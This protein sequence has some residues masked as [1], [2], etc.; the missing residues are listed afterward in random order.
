M[1][2]MGLWVTG[3]GHNNT[4]R[5]NAKYDKLIQFAK[6]SPDAKLRADSLAEAQKVLLEDGPIIPLCFRQ[7]V[8]AI[9]PYVKGLV[10]RADPDLVFAD[11]QK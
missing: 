3:G 2:Y 6:T 4:N 5:S 11:I 8:F 7:G 9:Q 1:T 10:K